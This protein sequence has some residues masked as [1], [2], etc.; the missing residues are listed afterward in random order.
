MLFNDKNSIYNYLLIKGFE[1][2]K[3]NYFNCSK[4]FKTKIKN[5]FKNSE[6]FENELLCLPNNNKI[7]QRYID[8]LFKNIENFYSINNNK[9]FN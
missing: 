1:T 8:Q 3:I 7:N 2:K 5:K 4:F 6:K 9:S